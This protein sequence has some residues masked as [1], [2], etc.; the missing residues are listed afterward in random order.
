MAQQPAVKRR[1]V[2][3]FMFQNLFKAREGLRSE[4]PPHADPHDSPPRL[5]APPGQSGSHLPGWIF[6]PT[7]VLVVAILYW[8]QE[9]LVPIAIA[10]LLTFILAPVVSAL[11]RLHLRR[12]PSVAVVTAL[13]VAI[14]LGA[15]WIVAWQMSGLANDLP[16]YRINILNKIDDLRA[17]KKGGALEKVEQTVEDVKT[18][19]KKTEDPTD[20]QP[21]EQPSHVVVAA[22]EESG[23]WPIPLATG[24]MAAS[25][26][27]K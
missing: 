11:E 10:V 12:I 20:K 19:L 14:L 21:S 27:P 7:L 6:L 4:A 17:F 23:F 26:R 16:R 1:R 3:D 8:A 15:S 13:S 9:V 2:N 25:C 18:E 24:P 22:E 5:Q